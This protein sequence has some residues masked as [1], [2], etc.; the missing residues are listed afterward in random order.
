MTF[1]QFRYTFQPVVARFGDKVFT[2]ESLGL[3]YTKLLPLDKEQLTSVVEGVLLE[4]NF[5]PSLSKIIA[6]AKPFLDIAH[7]KNKKQKMAEAEKNPCRRCD[8]S[9]WVECVD[10]GSEHRYITAFRCACVIG[11]NFVGPK[12]CLIWDENKYSNRFF[13]SYKV[14]SFNGGGTR[15]EH[16]EASDRIA[17]E[18]LGKILGVSGG[19]EEV[20][21]E[22]MKLSHQDKNKAIDD[23]ISGK[24]N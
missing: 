18:R 20:S 22:F 5:A 4:F 2:F 10:M 7:E 15:S 23:L 12:E 16:H 13:P 3:L 17:Y 14:K 9:G 24:Y 1:E 8:N 19:M 6:L 21:K 11:L